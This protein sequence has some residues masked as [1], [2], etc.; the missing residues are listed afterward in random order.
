MNAGIILNGLLLL[1]LSAFALALCVRLCLYILN[2]SHLKTHGDR[3]PEEFTGIVDREML[4]KMRDYTLATGRL[5]IVEQLAYDFFLL[6][7][8][9]SGVLPL[10]SGTISSHLPGFVIPGILFFF[11]CSLLLG[12]F[13]IPFDLYGTFGIERR[14]NVSTITVQTWLADLAKSVLVSAV[15]MGLFL[16]IFLSLISHAPRTWWLWAWIFFISFQLLVSWLYPVVIAPLFNK[17]EPIEDQDL[18]G[19]IRSLAERV[20]IRVKGIYRMDALKRSRHS[21]AYFTGIGK[22]KR[23]VLFDTLIQNHSR[24][25]ILAVLAHELGH[26]RLGHIRKQLMVS[27]VVSF[28]VFSGTYLAVTRGLL[29]ATFGFPAVLIYAGLFLLT[30]LAKPF[31][32]LLSPVGAMISRRFERQADDYAFKQI[33]DPEPLVNALKK[34]ATENLS[35]LHPNPA[36]AWFY[37]SHPPLVERIR[38]LKALPGQKKP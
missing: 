10:L 9:L 32:F 12:A 15:V 29:Y 36:Y 16:G 2:V 31:A 7:V 20:G 26:W 17:F 23:I 34:L 28:A 37:Y 18:L 19:D 4:T 24:E 11:S 6:A 21:N 8:L 5:G 13:G 22:S 1:F 25:E 38:R 35:N 33:G 27:I 3:V 14:F 30:I